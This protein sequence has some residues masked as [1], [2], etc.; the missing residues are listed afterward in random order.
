MTGDSIE[1]F[2]STAFKGGDWTISNYA[3]SKR[4]S[5][6]KPEPDLDG[7]FLVLH[8]RQRWSRT[9][10]FGNLFLQRRLIGII[11]AKPERGFQNA[12]DLSKEFSSDY[13]ALMVSDCLPFIYYV[14]KQPLI[15]VLDSTQQTTPTAIDT[16]YTV[17]FCK[18][19]VTALAGQPHTRRQPPVRGNPCVCA[20]GWV[21]TRTGASWDAAGECR[22]CRDRRSS[23]PPW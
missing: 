2:L 14:N 18:Q 11:V 8:P 7:G 9:K 3:K 10:L 15:Y 13:P 23:G 19:R 5:L 6:R 1:A 21:T 20:S 12:L 17:E 4:Q 16:G 22:Y